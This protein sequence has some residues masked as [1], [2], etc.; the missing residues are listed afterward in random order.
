M[1]GKLARV[2][3]AGLEVEEPVALEEH[4]RPDRH[5]RVA[6]DRPPPVLD[7]HRDDGRLGA[8]LEMADLDDLSDLDAGDPDRLALL[9]VVSRPEDRLDLVVVAHGQSAREREV[10]A[11]D[12]EGERDQAG[13]QRWH[14]RVPPAHGCVAPVLGSRVNVWPSGTRG[15]PAYVGP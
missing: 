14:S 4:A 15:I 9:H 1:T 5:P 8:R 11:H 10:G 12:D 6:V 13:A 3:S 2:R 7:A